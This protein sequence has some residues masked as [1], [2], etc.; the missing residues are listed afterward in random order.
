MRGSVANTAVYSNA[1]ILGDCNPRLAGDQLTLHGHVVTEQST[2]AA[3]A[4]LIN[5]ARSNAVCPAQGLD[6][7]NSAY[8]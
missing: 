7:I 6:D 8:A 4:L 2:L 5:G 3:Y 1:L